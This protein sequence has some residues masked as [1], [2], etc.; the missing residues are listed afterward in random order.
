MASAAEE[1]IAS[2]TVVDAGVAAI[3]TTRPKSANSSVENGLPAALRAHLR[4]LR[5]Y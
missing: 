4:A 3:S 5:L 2:M 1:R